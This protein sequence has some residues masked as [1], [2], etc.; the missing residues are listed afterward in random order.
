MTFIFQSVEL[1]QIWSIKKNIKLNQSII[2]CKRDCGYLKLPSY[3]YIKCVL[4]IK[5]NI[6]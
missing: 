5:Q 1:N 4:E 3:C 6:T 2:A